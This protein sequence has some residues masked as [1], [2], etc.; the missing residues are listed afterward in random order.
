[1]MIYDYASKLLQYL[2]IFPAALLCYLPMKE[3]CKYSFLRIFILSMAIGLPLIL[4]A[5]WISACFSLDTNIFLFPLML[6][7]FLIYQAT[8]T[9]GLGRSLTVFALVCALMAFPSNYSFAFDS[10]L[11]PYGTADQFSW[12]A[13]L[14]QLGLSLAF[15]ALLAYPFSHWGSRLIN[16]LDFS[17][18]WFTVLPIPLVF[19]IINLCA[20]PH[21]YET[22]H[23]NN[24]FNMY[25]LVMSVLLFLLLFI[26]ILF[27]RIS[28]V[29]ADSFHDRERIRFFE[30]QEYQ[31]QAQKRYMEETEKLRHDFRQTIHTL[32]GLTASQDWKAL[33]DYLCEYSKHLPTKEITRWC[34]NL[35]VNALLNY[36]A[37]IA[38][39]NGIQ[40]NWKI[41]LPGQTRIPET[42]LCSLLGNILENA[43]SGCLT[44]PMGERYH[45]LTITRKK[46]LSLY[47]VSI[48]SFDGRIRQKE[49]R[50]L[51]TKKNGSGIGLSSIAMTAEKYG[52][53]ASFSH[54]EH[55]FSIDVMLRLPQ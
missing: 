45:C 20:I 11:H 31:Y 47:I 19:L 17:R 55:E 43:L 14:F 41:E 22:M 49:G 30:M 1:M 7:F 8:L 3:K 44:A 39:Q 42:E 27:Y 23:T 46:E 10:W 54:S 25:I 5:S 26:F 4:G 12:E 48:N 53:M 28:M 6:L 15:A 16:S 18:I 40:L 33:D 32:Q 51:S 29:I 35:A 21:K 9:V 52:G 36:Y 24:V 50:Y 37:Y 2:V 34:A 38:E 13:A